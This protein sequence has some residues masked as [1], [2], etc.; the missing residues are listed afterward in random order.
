MALKTKDVYY[1]KKDISG[2][3]PQVTVK[4][5]RYNFPAL[6]HFRGD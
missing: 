2:S 5:K 3:L 4:T 6:R 1:L